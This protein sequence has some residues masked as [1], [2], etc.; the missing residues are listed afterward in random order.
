V[1]PQGGEGMTKEAEEAKEAKE[2]AR[3]DLLRLGVVWGDAT[4]SL[5]RLPRGAREALV[6]ER[7]K[8]PVASAL[9]G[10]AEEEAATAQEE[11]E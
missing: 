6:K 8:E 11:G 4:W 2:A 9:L 7:W 3:L 10:D 5:A 1:D